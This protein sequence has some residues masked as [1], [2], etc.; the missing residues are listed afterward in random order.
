MREEKEQ[1]ELAED[2]R[3]LTEQEKEH[4]I[5]AY[6]NRDWKIIIT[7]CI[8]CI[9]LI[10]G[11]SIALTFKDGI[12]RGIA[13]S[14]IV[15][16]G[17]LYIFWYTWHLTAKLVNSIK[18]NEIYVKEAIYLNSNKN[19]Y[20]SFYIKEKGRRQLFF[21]NAL[22]QDKVKN[23]EKVILISMGKKQVWVFKAFE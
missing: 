15:N 19:H 18:K 14:T 2:E 3:L 10:T 9:L 21:S 16:I 23:G 5:S 20:A 7:L 8:L 6:Q 1:I 4:I 11:I 22:N 12:G 17:I 13:F